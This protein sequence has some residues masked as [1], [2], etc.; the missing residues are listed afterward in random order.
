MILLSLRFL[1]LLPDRFQFVLMLDL[2]LF[3]RPTKLCDFFP[4]QVTVS[5]ISFNALFRV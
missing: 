4:E 3:Q 5:C 2:Y 1:E